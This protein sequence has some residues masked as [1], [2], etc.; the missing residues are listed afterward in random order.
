MAK[1]WH[2]KK[3]GHKLAY[4]IIVLVAL[5]ILVFVTVYMS[6]FQQ[7]T[8]Q[9]A[10]TTS[11]LEVYYAHLDEGCTCG[12]VGSQKSCPTNKLVVGLYDGS[13]KACLKDCCC[14][15]CAAVKVQGTCADINK[16][17]C[18]HIDGPTPVA[19]SGKW[20]SGLCPGASNIQC[21]SGILYTPKA[22]KAT[23]TPKPTCTS[24][25]GVC[26]DKTIY[27][28]LGGVGGGEWLKGL[29]PE[30]SSVQCCTPKSNLAKKDSCGKKYTYG[31]CQNVNNSCEGTEIA[32]DSLCPGS[33]SNVCCTKTF[34]LTNSY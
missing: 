30:G 9:H 14:S 11:C 8:Q 1:A 21:C 32:N 23:P 16:Y 20:Y 2:Q 12:A 19:G 27:N 6:Q 18:L 22:P 26:A 10:A 25:G 7:N 3:V 4:S 24:K 29:C 5:L 33:P 15:K 28:C 17:D 31:M 13:G 34:V